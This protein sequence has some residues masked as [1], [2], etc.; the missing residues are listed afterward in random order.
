MVL[1]FTPSAF[2]FSKLLAAA[3][4]GKEETLVTTLL[5]SWDILCPAWTAKKE[6]HKL[7]WCSCLIKQL[8][9]GSRTMGK[10]QIPW[11]WAKPQHLSKPKMEVWMAKRHKR[12]VS[13]L[14]G[15]RGKTI[16]WKCPCWYLNHCVVSLFPQTAIG[17][18]TYWVVQTLSNCNKEGV[19]AQQWSKTMV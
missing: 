2:L 15:N 1:T 18:G 7:H 8:K 16:K 12:A 11:G 3:W 4:G 6:S 5:A 10:S 17:L 19:F 14:Q 9:R 13:Q